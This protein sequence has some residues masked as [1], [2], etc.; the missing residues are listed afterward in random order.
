M[1]HEI[2]KSEI[3][4]ELKRIGAKRV[5]IQSPEGLRREAEELA[6]FLEENNIEVFYMEK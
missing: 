3:L 1:L 6:G 2:P 4:K 5:L